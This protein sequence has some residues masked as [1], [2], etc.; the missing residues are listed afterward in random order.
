MITPEYCR[1]M[2]RYSAWQNRQYF[3]LLEAMSRAEL[4]QD[5]GAFFGSILGTLNHLLW[6]DRIWM[7]RFDPS[8]EPPAGGIKESPSCT[9]TLG[10]WSAERF[11]MD[12]KISHWAES[13]RALDL[14]GDVTF[15][16]SVLGRTVSRPL[17]PCIAHMFNH[18]TH[19]RGQ[20]HAM[21]TAA[22]LTA[23]VSDLFLLPE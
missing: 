2:A 4:T 23:P 14:T 7:S 17:G 3:D 21:M 9:P 5:R 20:I 11:H 19:H 16:S 12:G 8:V 10:A 18:Q 15:T 13:L 1:T 22:G 6:A